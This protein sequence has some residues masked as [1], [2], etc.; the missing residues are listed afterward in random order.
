[1]W[2]ER[3]F[4]NLVYLKSDSL[5]TRKPWKSSPAVSCALLTGIP[6]TDVSATH[7]DMSA[8]ASIC[9]RG[10]LRFVMLNANR[11]PQ[12]TRLVFFQ[13]HLPR[14]CPVV[15]RQGSVHTQTLARSLGMHWAWADLLC[16]SPGCTGRAARCDA[17]A[18]LTKKE[19]FTCLWGNCRKQPGI[20]TNKASS[21]GSER[22]STDHPVATC[23]IF[24]NSYWVKIDVCIIARNAALSSVWAG[25]KAVRT[26][27]AASLH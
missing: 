9:R 1:M 10:N 22:I 7:S 21:C 14:L 15:N 11:P 16:G 6:L 2:K 27:S 18:G 12:G 3:S 25:R 20:L 13:Q 23:N 26:W 8:K 5:N 17:G 24:K 4:R 19:R